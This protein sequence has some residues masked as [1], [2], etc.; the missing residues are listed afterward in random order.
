MSLF[1]IKPEKNSTT[2][3]YITTLYRKHLQKTFKYSWRPSTKMLI[4]V[5]I[6]LRNVILILDI[7]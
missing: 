2:G 5:Y 4:N 7:I 3:V 6:N 1:I